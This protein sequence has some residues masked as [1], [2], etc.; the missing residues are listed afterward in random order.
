MFLVGSFIFLTTAFGAALIFIPN[1]GDDAAP[2]VTIILGAYVSI[3]GGGAV[4][5]L[6]TRELRKGRDE[7]DK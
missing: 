7:E 2:I 5:A 3:F 6:L 1:F 4:G